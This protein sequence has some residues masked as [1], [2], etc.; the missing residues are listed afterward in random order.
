MKVAIV[1]G[2]SGLVGSESVEFLCG[3]FDRVIGVDNDLRKAFFGPATRREV[4]EAADLRPREW[5]VLV[6]LLVLIVAIGVWPG[7]WLDIVRPAAEAWGAGL[8]R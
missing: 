4:T 7:P 6:I 8:A 2:S 3:K 1:T 5:A